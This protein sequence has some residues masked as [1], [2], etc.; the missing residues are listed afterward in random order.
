MAYTVADGQVVWDLEVPHYNLAMYQQRDGR[1]IPVTFFEWAV[2]PFGVLKWARTWKENGFL[3]PAIFN[4][5]WRNNT[6]PSDRNYVADSVGFEDVQA[7][8]SSVILANVSLPSPA[9]YT[10][11]HRR[12]DNI[13]NAVP[14]DP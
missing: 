7:N 9:P 5:H 8:S 13:S 3:P 12:S 1:R 2:I 6:R 11:R 14:T 10:S 4:G